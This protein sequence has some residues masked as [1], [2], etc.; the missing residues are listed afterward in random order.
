V[1]WDYPTM[2]PL[3]EPDAEAVLK[4]INGFHVESGEPVEGFTSLKEDGS[5]ACGC[6]IYSGAYRDGKNMTNRRTPYWEQN[7]LAPEWAWVWPHNRRILYNRASAD[8]DGKP[9]SE[10]KAL[11]WWD[12]NKGKWE[13]HDTPDFIVERAPT[14]R[15][16]Q[17]ARGKETISGIDPFV[18]Q[19]DGKGWIFAAAGLKDGPL[20]THYEPEESV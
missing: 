6:W 14:Y 15:P 1:T 20:P 4:E 18:M 2:G 5:T 9:W 19:P 11:V 10:R 7:W 17:E 8:P 16:S 12:D 3:Q 13:G